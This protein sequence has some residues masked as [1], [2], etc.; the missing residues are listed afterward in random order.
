MKGAK[1]LLLMYCEGGVS[2]LDRKYTR[3]KIIRDAIT[4]LA[5]QFEPG[6]FLKVFDERKT[7][8]MS[9]KQTV[10]GKRL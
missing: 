4:F 5:R 6:R 1:V 2:T 7:R 10:E 9:T 8:I 3:T